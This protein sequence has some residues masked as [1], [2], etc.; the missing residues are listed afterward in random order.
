[1][2]VMAALLFTAFPTA[3]AAPVAPSQA[4]ICIEAGAIAPPV[5][6]LCH[7]KQLAKTLSICTLKLVCVEAAEIALLPP[8]VLDR[9]AAPLLP[10]PHR[11][12]E[13]LFR[14]PREPTPLVVV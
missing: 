8:P 1:M 3:A 12:A 11:A 6:R 5:D 13:S 4:E 7:R 2:G 9:A 10:A 14:P